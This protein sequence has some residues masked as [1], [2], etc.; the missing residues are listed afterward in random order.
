MSIQSEAAPPPGLEPAPP[1]AAAAP[2]QRAAAP[3]SRLKL[4]L[5]ANVAGTGSSSLMQIAFVPLY[6]RYM[7]I[8]AYGLVGFFVALQGVLQVLDLGFSPTMNREMAR[9]SV[10]PER[11][12]EARDLARTLEL[13]YWALGLVIGLAI[14]AIAPWI[15][16]RWVHPASLTV[17]VV[18]QAI[19]LM[20]LLSLVQ[21]PLTLYVGG[22]I[23][24]QRQP[25]LNAL[26]VALAAIGHFGA[27]LILWRVSPT[28]TAFLSWQIVVSTLRL[29]LLGMAFWRSVPPAERAARFDLTRMR[30]IWR[31]SAGMGGITVTTLILT[32]ADKVILSKLISLQMFGYYTLA[33]TVGGG[34]AVIAGPVFNLVFPQ[35]SALVASGNPNLIKRFYHQSA[36]LMAVIILPVASLLA[37]FSSDILLAWT[38]T[39]E[40]AQN[41]G[42]I[43]TLLAVGS[44]LNSVMVLP[45]SLQLA[46][47]WTWLGVRLNT[48]FIV[49]LV[50]A[51]IVLATRYGPAGAAATWAMLNGLYLI[52]G[53]PLTYRRLLKGEGRR[54]ILED[55]A[56]PAFGAVAVVAAARA[57]LP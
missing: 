24:L 17:G 51:L 8:E 16:T 7:G 34:V 38:G 25:L 35:L 14:W 29:A 48:L 4:N 54:W 32:Q 49:L 19:V 3:G 47:G 39:P 13:G 55:V 23:G 52:L 31:F 9:Y 22:L 37:F 6:I 40:V 18:R 10:Q 27:V 41:A 50:P 2:R 21:W 28:I 5:L 56:L 1:P 26:Q 53:A 15:A 46:Y 45:Y 30:D 20:G 33:G 11:A 44:A 36:Q 12:T 43:V 42:P 57:L